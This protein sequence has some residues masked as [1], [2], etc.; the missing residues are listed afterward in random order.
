MRR[1]SGS[2]LT[3]GG[4]TLRVAGYVVGIL[5]LLFAA[6]QH[7]ASADAAARLVLRGLDGRTFDWGFELMIEKP[8]G[9]P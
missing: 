6:P 9:P 5:A 4:A 1:P 8:W 2:K 3:T 7:A